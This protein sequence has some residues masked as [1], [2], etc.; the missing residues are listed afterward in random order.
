MISNLFPLQDM[1]HQEQERRHDQGN[2]NGLQKIAATLEGQSCRVYEQETSQ[3]G[4]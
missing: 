1:L 3:R 2:L 4:L